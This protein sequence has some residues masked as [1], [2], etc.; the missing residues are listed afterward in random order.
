[1]NDLEIKKQAKAFAE[2]WKDRGYEKGE[3]QKF[4]LDLL[5]HVLGVSNAREYISFEDQIKIEKTS[6]IDGYIPSTKVLIEQKSS[7]V[8]LNKGIK[9]SDGSIL[10][11]F[12]Q[13]KRYNSKQIHSKNARWII[14]CNFKEFHIY[15]MNKIDPQPEVI[16]LKNLPKEYYRLQFIV[17]AQNENIKKEMEISIKAGEIVGVLYDA[18]LKQ[19]NEKDELELT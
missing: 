6:F 17:N 14:T 1:M 11:P 3:S 15:D 19:Y 10:T 13:A 12:E 16:K 5:E 9:Q 18:L 7:S 4:W 2:Y 8:D